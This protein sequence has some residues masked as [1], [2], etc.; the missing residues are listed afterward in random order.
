[1]E[2]WSEKPKEILKPKGDRR[3]IVRI[4]ADELAGVQKKINKIPKALKE[5]LSPGSIKGFFE[6]VFGKENKIS[7]FL[8]LIT[9]SLT[10]KFKFLN[11]V[12]IPWTDFMSQLNAAAEKT[13]KLPF[14]LKDF[15]VSHRALGY[16]RFKE[17]SK[18][19]IIAAIKSGEKQLEIDLRRGSDG[20]I[21]L[22][23]EPIENIE[24]TK[25][26][27]TELSEALQI[28]AEN[29]HQDVIIFFDIK[30]QG[31]VE[32]LDLTI[33]KYDKKY[34]KVE[35][36]PIANRHFVMG[37][38]FEILKSS[39]KLNDKRPLIFCYIPVY[40]LEGL[41]RFIVKLGQ[42]KMIEIC[43]VIDKFTGGHLAKDLSATCVT[44]NDEKI[45]ETNTHGDSFLGIFSRLPS[46]EV[47]KIVDYVCVPAILTGPTL[48]KQLHKKN[49]N[50]AVWGV[51]ER[52]IQDAIIETGADLVI[53]DNPFIELNKI[54]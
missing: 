9:T 1:M 31:I 51:S 28:I 2:N 10:G 8:S 24:N 32:E 13:A 38:D 21:Y 46:D 25:D 37:F 19:A 30:E 5:I 44:V 23:H 12:K 36:M 40:K 45:S 48:V 20:K 4:M 6:K 22:S 7:S 29:E 52:G 15:I 3:D 54:S 41:S 14:D 18:E 11:R 17:N 27:F 26:Q 42:K 53:T 16:G 49:V 39:R 34:K 50:V 47:L 43:R 33:S 35:Y